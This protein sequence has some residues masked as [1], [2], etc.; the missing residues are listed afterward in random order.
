MSFSFCTFEK[1]AVVYFSSTG[2]ARTCV[3]L[4]SCKGVFLIYFFY[5]EKLNP[6]IWHRDGKIM[7]NSVQGCAHFPLNQQQETKAHFMSL[8]PISHLHPHQLFL[9]HA[10]KNKNVHMRPRGAQ[11]QIDHC[12]HHC[13]CFSLKLVDLSH[14]SFCWKSQI[15]FPLH[16]CYGACVKGTMNSIQNNL[17]VNLALLFILLLKTSLLQLSKFLVTQSKK[18][19]I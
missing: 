5:T 1:A 18:S 10:C 13:I 6:L 2:F 14:I 4:W 17:P 15:R 19:W 8:Q 11:D 7:N 12:P 16:G 3:C 9:S